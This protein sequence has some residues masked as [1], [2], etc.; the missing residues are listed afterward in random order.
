MGKLPKDRTQG[1]S[2]EEA[3]WIGA[4]RMQQA[5]TVRVNGTAPECLISGKFAYTWPSFQ[6]SLFDPG[7]GA[8][9]GVTSIF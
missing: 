9:Q 3:E 5:G 4:G 6:Y 7:E 2:V 8:L 1:M